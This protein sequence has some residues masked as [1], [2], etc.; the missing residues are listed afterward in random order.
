MHST[1]KIKEKA[2]EKVKLKP[3]G[4]SLKKVLIVPNEGGVHVEEVK[5]QLGV[6]I[7][8]EYMIPYTSQRGVNIAAKVGLQVVCVVGKSTPVK[9]DARRVVAILTG[10]L[11]SKSYVVGY[12]GVSVDGSE[13]ICSCEINFMDMGCAS[14][15]Q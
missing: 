10:L 3:Y 14:M 6:Q 15:E 8:R 12:L 5:S 11:S 4:M 9:G 2:H 7:K 13:P 1:K